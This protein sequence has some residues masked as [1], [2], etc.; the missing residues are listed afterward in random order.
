MVREE[1]GSPV[2]V[3]MSLEV[4]HDHVVDPLGRGRVA[5]GVCHG[6]PSLLQVIPHD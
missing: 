5:A 3:V 2:G 6:A 4:L 1:E